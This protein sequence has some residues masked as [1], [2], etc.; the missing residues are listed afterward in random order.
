MGFEVEDLTDPEVEAAA[1][2]L[3][4]WV[5]APL[6]A[7]EARRRLKAVERAGVTPSYMLRPRTLR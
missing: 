6:Q 2:L 7:A 5:T 4:A 1:T 3:K